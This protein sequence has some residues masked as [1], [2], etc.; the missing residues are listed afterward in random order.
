MNEIGF[1]E[2]LEATETLRGSLM[3]YAKSPLPADPGER[4][5]DM[6]K[7]IQNGDDSGRLLADAE[8]YLIQAIAQA[9]M[10]ARRLHPDLNAKEREAIVKDAVRGI[11][12]VVDGIAVTDRSIKSRIFAMM[13]AARSR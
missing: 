2:W 12:R 3:E 9:V 11:Q 13:N 4:H 1:V 10:E 5:M 8:G 7:A 6:D